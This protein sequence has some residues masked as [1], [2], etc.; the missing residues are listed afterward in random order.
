LILF[1]E[2]VQRS[3]MRSSQRMRLVDDF[4]Q[5]FQSLERSANLKRYYVL[6]IK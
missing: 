4:S 2:F 3:R 5:Q 6:L 1:Q